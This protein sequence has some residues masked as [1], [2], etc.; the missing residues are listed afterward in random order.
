LSRTGRRRGLSGTR[1]DILVAARRGFGARGYEATTFRSI[2]E[3]VGVDPGLLVHYF[4]TKEGLFVAALSVTLRPS[5]L[6]GDLGEVSASD[7]AELIV[8]RYLAMLDQDETRDMVLGL[9]R[10]AVSNERA[11][12]MLGEFV[13]QVM[14]SSLSELINRSDAELRAALAVAQLIGIAMLRHVVKE[15]TIVHASDDEL[16]SLVAPVIASYLQ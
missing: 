12:G 11:A 5:E 10:S 8:R 16:V 13:A 15:G 7:A 6:F 2:A 1:E 4:G 14:R 9:V 3:D